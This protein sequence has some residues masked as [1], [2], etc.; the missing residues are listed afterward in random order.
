MFHVTLTQPCSGF[1]FSLGL[2]LGLG[3]L[4]VG[5][6]MAA[7]IQ[8][9]LLVTFIR[10]ATVAG[11][12][13]QEDGAVLQA[14]GQYSRFNNFQSCHELLFASMHVAAFLPCIQVYQ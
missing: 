10:A 6:N 9:L 3:S 12:F 13:V 5:R 2:S 1:G 7:Q 11:H 4:G 8:V 14:S